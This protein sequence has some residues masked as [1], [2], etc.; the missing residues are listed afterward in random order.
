MVRHIFRHSS[1][2]FPIFENSFEKKSVRESECSSKIN[3]IQSEYYNAKSS[4][5][6]WRKLNALEN[7]NKLLHNLSRSSKNPRNWNINS[8][9]NEM[10]RQNS[11]PLSYS[12]N[13]LLPFP[14]NHNSVPINFFIIF[15]VEW[16]VPTIWMEPKQVQFNFFFRINVGYERIRRKCL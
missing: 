16:T 2:L 14:T 4:T 10:L 13:L 5:E 1:S 6:K 8:N 7:E 15:G 11:I 9:W 3:S 12:L